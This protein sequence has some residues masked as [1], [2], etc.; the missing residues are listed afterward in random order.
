MMRSVINRG[1]QFDMDAAD[2]AVAAFCSALAAALAGV[3]ARDRC[4]YHLQEGEVE[5]ER[6]GDESSRVPS[7]LIRDADRQ[8]VARRTT[9]SD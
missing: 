2:P 5:S 6:T 8:L 3:V 1:E 7:G 9:T 4:Q